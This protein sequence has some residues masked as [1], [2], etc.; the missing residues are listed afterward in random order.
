MTTTAHPTPRPPRGL[1]QIP[2]GMLH[3]SPNNPRE[4]IT[5]ID[6]LATSMREHGLIQ[7]IVVQQ[8]PGQ[9]GFQIL[10][11][12]RRHAAAVK[13]GWPTVPAIVRRDMRPDEELTL[14]LVEN[15]QRAGLDP[16]EEARA[17]KRLV[18]GGMRKDQVA[19][20]IGRSLSHVDMRL[21][22]LR[23]TPEEQEE[24]RAGVTPL[25][26]AVR[27]SRI[28]AGVTRATKKPAAW[29]HFST[30]HHLARNAKARCLRLNHAANLRV[31]GG[32]ACG[33]CW[34]AVIRSDE[35]QQLVDDATDRGR[36]ATCGHQDHP[37]PVNH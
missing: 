24:I 30:T 1:T 8:V 28:D 23:L 17:I 32:L 31:V 27:K 4:H 21:S 37:Q 36:C 25:M 18:T 16:I 19:A 3:P 6:A 35:R 13:L 9:A 22:L 10:A 29:R 15:G 5:D 7:P 2:T 20:K 11:G 26:A 12:H 14:M 33:E 34:E